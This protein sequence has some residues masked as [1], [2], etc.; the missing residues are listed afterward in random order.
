MAVYVDPLASCR[1]WGREYRTV[2]HMIADTRAE[3][4]AL[5]HRIGLRGAWFQGGASTPHYDLTA[6]K[7][8]QAVDRGA[9]ELTAKEMAA[10]CGELRKKPE[11]TKGRIA[12]GPTG[13]LFSG[14][15]V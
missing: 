13:M 5:A 2:S 14:W 10:K 15:S 11:P 9:V 8:I 1:A 3:L 12:H 4:H 6:S 7:R